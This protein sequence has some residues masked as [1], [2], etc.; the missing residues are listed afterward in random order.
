MQMST[1]RL[2]QVSVI[3]PTHNYG[4]YL[5]EALSSVFAQTLRASEIIVVDD[6]STDNT[7]EVL[8]RISDSRL[9]VFHVSNSGVS[10]ARNI[11]LDAARGDIITF[12]DADDRWL[13]NMLEMQVKLLCAE[14]EVTSAF[15]NFVRFTEGEAVLPR[16][17]FS[18][19]PELD[20]IPVREARGGAGKV[21]QGDA[22][23]QLVKFNEIP[24][25]TQVLAFK[26]QAV[27]GRRFNS[28][29]R[30]CEDT[31][32]MLQTIR[33]ERVA[34]NATVL[35]EVRR[36]GR[37]V[38]RDYGV[39]TEAKLRALRIVAEGDLTAAQR[40]ALNARLVKAYVDVARRQARSRERTRALRTLGRGMLVPGS[41]IRKV[42]GL[43]RVLQEV[44]G[45]DS[46]AFGGIG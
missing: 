7:E 31:E 3:I 16:D 35:A 14:P 40:K 10:R 6:G 29:L 26:A 18:Y 11:G 38:T 20:E 32:F 27:K 5:P 37:N 45:A 39:L 19:Y 21:I 2:I 15:A 9:Q 28:A 42:K 12:L 22:F 43:I 4:K 1:T 44:V 23:C 46:G 17:Q 8:A 30:L 33:G 41:A 13:P 34:F 25:F 24:A 36:H